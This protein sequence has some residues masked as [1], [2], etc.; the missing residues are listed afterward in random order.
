MPHHPAEMCV[1]PFRQDL[2]GLLLIRG[3]LELDLDEFVVLQGGFER[4]Y[5]RVRD[6]RLSHA[7]QGF[8]PVSYCAQDSTI[9]STEQ[10]IPLFN[11]VLSVCLLVSRKSQNI[12]PIGGGSMLPL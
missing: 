2:R 9:L 3:L 7:D 6:A 11:H 4:A 1:R 12:F 5:D 8:S 10:A